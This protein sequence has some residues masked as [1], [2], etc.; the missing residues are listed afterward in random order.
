MSG[1]CVVHSIFDDAGDVVAVDVSRADPLI[2]IAETLINDP[3]P[4]CEYGEGIF[5]VNARGGTVRYRLLEYKPEAHAWSA[6]RIDH[7]PLTAD[8]V[9][10]VGQ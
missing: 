6:Q 7:S 5:V 2:L 1:V 4:F 9:S 8:R 10:G 3:A